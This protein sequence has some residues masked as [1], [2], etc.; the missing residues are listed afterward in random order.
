MLDERVLGCHLEEPPEI[1]EQWAQGWP[2]HKCWTG[3]VNTLT[4]TYVD[5]IAQD[6]LG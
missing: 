6:C 2:E 5:Q 3:R 1:N 4:E